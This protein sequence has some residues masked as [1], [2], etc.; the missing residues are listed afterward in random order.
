MLI[1]VKEMLRNVHLQNRE[2]TV[3]GASSHVKM[4]ST[5]TFLSKTDE[6]SLTFPGQRLESPT[7]ECKSN[8][9][10]ALVLVSLSTAY[11]SSL[12]ARSAPD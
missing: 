4:T 6:F 2:I 9:A 7:S 5:L 12:P 10:S 3:Y 8:A 1:H 11:S